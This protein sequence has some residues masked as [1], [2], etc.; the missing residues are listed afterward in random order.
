MSVVGR[1]TRGRWTAACAGIALLVAA[2][3]LVHGAT[4]WYD[5]A[6]DASAPAPAALLAA[7]ARSSEIG[8]AGLAEARGTLGLPDLTAFGSVAALLGQTTRLRVWWRTPQA[9][10]VDTVTT[11]GETGTYGAGAQVVVWD[12]ERRHLRTEPGSPPARLPRADD[13]L[14]PQATRRLLAGVGPGDPLRALPPKR[15]AGRLAF[16]VRVTPADA[17]STLGRIDVWVDAETDS[18]RLPLELRVY[19]RFGTAALVSRFLEVRPGTPD[20]GVLTPPSP[21]GAR[22][23]VTQTPDVVARFEAQAPW[24]L[25][26]ELAGLAASGPLLGGASS[27]GS[28]LVTVGLV[29]L[30]GRLGGRLLRDARAAGA[31]ELPVSG[32]AAVLVSSSIL[33]AALVRGTDREHAYLLTGMVTPDLLQRAAEQLLA[34]PPPRRSS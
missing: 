28:G 30:P 25:P 2:P 23:E 20:A 9:W 8:Y 16:G 22:L 27:Y 11:T 4:R 29:P 21:S 17:R 5:A 7:A 3:S 31:T 19:D 32:G 14:P 34:D 1:A 15:I 6:N 13:L 18:G 24:Q 26:D 12:Y 10:R 33:N